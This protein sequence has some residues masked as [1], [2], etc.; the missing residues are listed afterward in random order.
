MKS[1]AQQSARAPIAISIALIAGGVAML[2]GMQPTAPLFIVI[3]STS[4]LLIGE[5]IV[6]WC[7]VIGLLWTFEDTYVTATT[8][9]T[10]IG[11]MLIVVHVNV[12]V[13][14]LFQSL[15]MLRGISEQWIFTVA[16][17]VACGVYLIVYY[18]L[19]PTVVSDIQ[20]KITLSERKGDR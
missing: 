14:V 18:Y 5:Y 11:Y 3:G 15:G 1:L 19:R 4:A 8:T 20:Y 13:Y 6:A 12:T 10:K 16:E 17:M 9:E 2:N 7:S